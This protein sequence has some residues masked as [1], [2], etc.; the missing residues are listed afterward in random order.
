MARR[1]S[2]ARRYA[3]AA[4]ELATAEGELDRWA[5][6]L[7][8]AETVLGDPVA[9]RVVDN[10]A[11]PLDARVDVLD[12]LLPR[13]SRR[14][15]NLLALLVQRGGIPLLPGIVAEYTRLL[16]RE[17][18]IVPAVVTTAMPLDEEGLAA[19]RSQVQ[20]LADATVDLRTEVDSSLIGG[21]T[22]RIGDR[23]IDGSV[24][25]RLERLRERLVLEA[26]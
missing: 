26:R 20:R 24:R 13:L 25:G 6:E 18:G 5:A 3:E 16:N 14:V 1:T 19:V 11:L 12:R 2:A 17:R 10:P 22:I 9:A 4:F 23:L 7:R 21:L 15:R 8:V